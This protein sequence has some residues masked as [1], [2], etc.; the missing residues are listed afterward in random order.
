[1]TG[2]WHLCDDQV[3]WKD[4]ARPGDAMFD[5]L[6]QHNCGDAC[7]T[8]GGF[9]PPASRFTWRGQRLEEPLYAEPK[10][11]C[12]FEDQGNRCPRGSHPRPLYCIG[13]VSES[14]EKAFMLRDELA[15]R[16]M[17]I[18]R[19][20]APRGKARQTREW[21]RVAEVYKSWR[22]RY[23]DNSTFFSSSFF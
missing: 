2:M 22:A 9:S 21:L 1:M 7:R 14:K 10:K 23:R 18:R 8:R 6:A 12:V 13:Y 17:T 11:R 4:R 16:V 15:L 20:L 3:C 5:R 19:G